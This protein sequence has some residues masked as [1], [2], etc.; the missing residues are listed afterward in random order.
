MD[1]FCM[2]ADVDWIDWIVR[3]GITH[4]GRSVCIEDEMYSPSCLL[5]PKLLTNLR[6]YNI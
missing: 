2:I 6:V 3:M 5:I 4:R 1:V